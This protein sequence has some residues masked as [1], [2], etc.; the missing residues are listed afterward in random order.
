MNDSFKAAGINWQAPPGAITRESNPILVSVATGIYN[1][2]LTG[3]F[4]SACK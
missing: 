4:R 2:Y 3:W 1:N